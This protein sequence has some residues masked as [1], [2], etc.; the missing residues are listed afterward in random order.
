MNDKSI[1]SRIVILIRRGS[2]GQRYRPASP[3]LEYWG[4][5]GGH[6]GTDFF[7]IF[8]LKGHNRQHSGK[9]SQNNQY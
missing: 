9:M 1:L 6:S 5:G 2:L 7:F 3:S 8:Y 4:G